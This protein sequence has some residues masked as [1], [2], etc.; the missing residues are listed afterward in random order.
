M[1]SKNEIKYIQSL[2]HKK[3]RD[4]EEVFIAEGV[5]LVNE[6]LQSDIAI[7][8]IYATKEWLNLHGNLPYAKE[9]Q[10]DELKKISSQSTPHEVVAIARQKKSAKEPLLKKKIILALDGIQDPGNM[11]TIIRIADWFGIDQVVAG[12]DTADLYNSK[13][14]QSTMGSI[15]RVNVW[16]KNLEEWLRNIGVQVYG[17]L[18]NGK[19]IFDVQNVEEG[20]LIIGNESKG[21]RKNLLQFVQHPLTIPKKGNAES[22]NAAVATGIILSHLIK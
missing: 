15:A 14:V 19:N 22:L 7:K 17:A 16:Y 9:V 2:S 1:L 5:K 12:H 8:K 3:T 6:L 18:L 10:Y 13:V 11:G 20:I 21:I 4:D